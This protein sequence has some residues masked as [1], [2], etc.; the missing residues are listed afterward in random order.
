M[1]AFIM[2]SRRLS[3]SV[4]RNTT[5]TGHLHKWSCPSRQLGVRLSVCVAVERNRFLNPVS[6]LSDKN[7]ITRRWRTTASRCVFW[8]IHSFVAGGCASPWSFGRAIQCVSADGSRSKFSNTNFGGCADSFQYAV[9]GCVPY[10]SATKRVPSRGAVAIVCQ[11]AEQACRWSTER[12]D[13]VLS[14]GF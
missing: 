11:P 5:N 1:L 12:G 4:M 2:G 3:R 9:V 14:G 6:S 10:F 7:R 8:C 13:G